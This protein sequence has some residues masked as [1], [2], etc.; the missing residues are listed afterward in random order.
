MDNCSIHKSD[1]IREAIEKVGA[2]LIFLP[3]DSPD[4]SPIENC[5][6]KAKTNLKKLE[7]R[8]YPDLVQAIRQSL[9]AITIEDIRNWFT[10]CCYRSS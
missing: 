6:S 4:F 1:E 7:P 5:W 2:K 9:D 3:P 10:H 8:T